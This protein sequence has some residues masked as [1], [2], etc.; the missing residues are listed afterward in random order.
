MTAVIFFKRRAFALAKKRCNPKNKM[1]I[2]FGGQY[3]RAV[4]LG[5]IAYEKGFLNRAA[6]IDLPRLEHAFESLSKETFEFCDSIV[7]KKALD[8][9][10]EQPSSKE[11]MR[12]F[13]ELA[14]HGGYRDGGI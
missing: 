13:K 9:L 8:F 12:F 5:L 10:E 11:H 2:I 14:Y 6:V 3:K 1:K 4:K 7:I